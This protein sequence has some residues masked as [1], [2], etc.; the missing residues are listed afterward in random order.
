MPASAP[1][2][3]RA[4]L[5]VTDKTGLADFARKLAALGREVR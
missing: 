5:S 1:K 4:I 3:H 2:I